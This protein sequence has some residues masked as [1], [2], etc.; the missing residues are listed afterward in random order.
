MLWV[1]VLRG[2]YIYQ[3]KVT[4]KTLPLDG[5]IWALQSYTPLKLS[6]ECAE[7]RTAVTFFRLCLI[8][9]R[10]SFQMDFQI[11]LYI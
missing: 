10:Q 3:N 6:P 2:Q 9:I 1:W 4:V 11:H 5:A 8:L 7:A